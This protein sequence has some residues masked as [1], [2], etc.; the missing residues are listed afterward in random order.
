LAASGL[1]GIHSKFIFE[2]I[3]VFKI[4]HIVIKINYILIKI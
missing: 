2:T 4:Y 1:V 3:A